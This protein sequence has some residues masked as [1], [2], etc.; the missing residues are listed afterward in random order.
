MS[1]S[2]YRLKPPITHLTLKAESGHDR[3]KIWV[4][5]GLVGELVLANRETRAFLDCFTLYEADNECPLRSYWGGPERG[6]VVYANEDNLPDGMMVISQYGELL[7]V[8]QV[9]A[10]NGAKRKDGFPTELFGYEKEE[11]G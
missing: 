9:K 5:H 1:T 8:A 11:Q 2:Y 10:R 4:N 3:L 7:T 6:T